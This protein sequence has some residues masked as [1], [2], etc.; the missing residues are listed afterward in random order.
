MKK[1]LSD[2]ERLHWLENNQ[3]KNVSAINAVRGKLGMELLA[4]PAKKPKEAWRKAVT[5]GKGKTRGLRITP[6]HN[7]QNRDR[8]GN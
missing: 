2:E 3:P 6:Y 7:W 4:V 5:G 1:L 8:S